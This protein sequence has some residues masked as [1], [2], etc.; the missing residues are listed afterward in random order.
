METG[1]TTG[2]GA[3]L[4]APR[5]GDRTVVAAQSLEATG[6]ARG[7]DPEP[8]AAELSYRISTEGEAVVS[9]G[10]ELDIVNADVTVGYVADVI[11][12]C[13]GPLAVDLASLTFCDAS[14]LRALERMA[15]YAEQAGRPFRLAAPGQRLVKIMRITGLDRRFLAALVPA[16]AIRD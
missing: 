5:S 13:L 2:W 14:G 3:R 7:D 10:G 4:V 8:L 11:D 1:T 9:I 12:Q 16:Q 15:D 6:P